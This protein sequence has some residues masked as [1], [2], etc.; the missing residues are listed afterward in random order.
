L[1]NQ[2]LKLRMLEMTD[3]A[4]FIIDELEKHLSNLKGDYL[5]GVIKSIC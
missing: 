3:S 1:T 2:I 5:T 4:E